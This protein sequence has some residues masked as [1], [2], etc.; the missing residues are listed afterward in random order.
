MQRPSPIANAALAFV[1]LSVPAALAA[2][3]R[4]VRKLDAEAI[5]KVSE[6]KLCDAY[7]VWLSQGKQY[8]VIDG[9]LRRRGIDCA[10]AV[11]RLVSNCS[12]LEVVEVE[13]P[14]PGG[15]VYTV[16]NLS[17]KPKSFRI[18]DGGMVSSRFSIGA[19]STQGFGVRSDPRIAGL[20]GVAAKLEGQTGVE[21]TE[22]V[23][24]SW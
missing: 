21:L 13:N 18:Y 16:R 5:Q 4:S 14:F 1:L 11:D 24:S 22:C 17:A 6:R 8:P 19:G 2:S 10:D 9:E 20:G 3:P 7:G 12:V 23:T 15:M